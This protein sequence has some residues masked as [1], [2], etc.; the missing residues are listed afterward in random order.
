MKAA[1][2]LVLADSPGPLEYDCMYVIDGVSRLQQIPWQKGSTYDST[3]QRYGDAALYG[4]AV[5]VIDGDENVPSTT[6][7][8]H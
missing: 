3:C 8:I 4:N 6:D 2:M 1:N 7:K 5:V